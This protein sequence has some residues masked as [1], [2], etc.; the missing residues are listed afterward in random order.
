MKLITN[1]Y[2]ALKALKK[3]KTGQVF[4]TFAPELKNE[5]DIVLEA[6]NI[7]GYAL[8]YAS[9]RL[10]N[11]EEI[12]K[13]A[14][15][16]HQLAFKH[17]GIQI[18]KNEKFIIDNLQSDI[19]SGEVFKF[20][21]P[22][23]QK[24]RRFAIRFVEKNAFGL[25]YFPAEFK[26]DKEIAQLA[27]EKNEYSFRYINKELRDTLEFTHQALKNS[28]NFK[29][30]AKKYKN[31]EAIALLAIDNL[32]DNEEFSNFQYIGENLKNNKEFF[33]KV[34]L[35]RA[36]LF[37]YAGN[38]LKKDSNFI[39]YFFDQMHIKV[40][41]PYND[42]KELI[43]P[44]ILKNFYYFRFASEEILNDR[45]ILLK[46]LKKDTSAIRYA[47]SEIKNMLGTNK[48]LYI[49]TLE[50]IINIEALSEKLNKDLENKP[51]T[52]KIKI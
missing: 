48:N 44:Q 32:T 6:V 37:Q 52:T 39:K 13:K 33:K 51:V 25:K 31:D 12:V 30:I 22:E 46:A 41:Y 49:S 14:V 21:S 5:V 29:I 8:K 50:K 19:T 2:D 11:N 7:H 17:A 20:C 42:Y 34:I 27:L 18:M 28:D 9:T 16:K 15:S 26:A 47:S 35:K 23:L 1:K 3:S 45:H 40:D 43:Q 38:E 36:V 10:K 24:N 4:K